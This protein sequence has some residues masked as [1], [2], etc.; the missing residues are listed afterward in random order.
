LFK[1]LRV[2][3][4]TFI[5][6]PRMF[7]KKSPFFNLRCLFR[8]VFRQFLLGNRHFFSRHCFFHKQIGGFFAVGKKSPSRR[9]AA[10][11]LYAYG[12]PALRQFPH[13]GVVAALEPVMLVGLEAHPEAVDVLFKAGGDGA[14]CLVYG[15]QF[16]FPIAPGDIA[17]MAYDGGSAGAEA[18]LE[19][20]ASGGI[21]DFRDTEQAIFRRVAPFLK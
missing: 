15:R 6:L 12:F 13:T 16:D 10:S 5:K 21:H 4:K 18:L 1:N 11:L 14:T 9:Q 8:A 7:L 2:K 20:P 3:L 19:L 17:D